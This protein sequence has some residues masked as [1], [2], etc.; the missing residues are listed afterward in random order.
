MAIGTIISPSGEQFTFDGI[1]DICD[2]YEEH[3][4]ETNRLWE[5]EWEDQGLEYFDE[6]TDY[7][8]ARGWVEVKGD[9][10][11]MVDFDSKLTPEA[12]YTLFHV[13]DTLQP[14]S[15]SVCGP[16]ETRHRKMTLGEVRHLTAG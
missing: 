7:A 15:I 4:P 3:L 8:M 9:D 6:A 13:L 5:E 10:H 11:V 16:G 2:I 12:A 1:S 14:K